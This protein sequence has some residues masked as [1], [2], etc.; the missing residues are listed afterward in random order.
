MDEK[1]KI[2]GFYKVDEST[3][4]NKDTEALKAYKKRKSKMR[5][6]DKMEE[7]I[8]ELKNSMNEIKDLLKGL[9]K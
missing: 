7:D 9:V 5:K 2:P 1:T 8:A 6:V 4:I 3:V